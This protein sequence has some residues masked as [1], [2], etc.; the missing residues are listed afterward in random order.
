MQTQFHNQPLFL[1]SA[2][3]HSVVADVS[4][5]GPLRVAALRSNMAATLPSLFKSLSD[6]ETT[7]VRGMEGGRMFVKPLH[8]SSCNLTG[9]I[10]TAAEPSTSLY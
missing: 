2:A 1:T 5:A 8:P 6:A 7:G 3:Q 4:S 9:E 10:T